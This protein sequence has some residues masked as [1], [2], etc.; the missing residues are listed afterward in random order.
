MRNSFVPK[1]I[2]EDEDPEIRSKYFQN[3]IMEQIN[4]MSMAS[5]MK[6]N[7]SYDETGEL[8]YP[9]FKYIYN[10]IEQRFKILNDKQEELTKK[11]DSMSSNTPNRPP[12]ANHLN[13]P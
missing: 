10:I 12:S 5:S 7:F 4:L 8:V 3:Y 13:Y 6:L 2:S 11:I 9:E 1:S